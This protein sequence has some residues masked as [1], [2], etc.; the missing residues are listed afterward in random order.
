MPTGTVLPD[1]GAGQVKIVNDPGNDLDLLS[2]YRDAAAELKKAMGASDANVCRGC[3]PTT[4]MGAY[5]IPV[6][7]RQARRLRGGTGVPSA[8]HK[9]LAP[10]GR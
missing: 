9:R 8:V 5:A 6:T 1:S 7:E 4:A 2:V 3:A 10:Y